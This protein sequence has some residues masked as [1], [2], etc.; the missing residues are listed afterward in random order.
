M[1]QVAAEV[2][3]K[4]Y[5]ALRSRHSCT[6][7]SF[8]AAARLQAYL[9]VCIQRWNRGGN[10]KRCRDGM[11]ATCATVG[12]F[13]SFSGCDSCRPSKVVKHLVS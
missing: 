1:M 2:W 10:A 4:D 9:S 6:S 7:C 3:T 5:R 8:L 11:D 13:I 12:C